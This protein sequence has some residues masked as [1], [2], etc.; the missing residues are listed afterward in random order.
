MKK[1]ILLCVLGFF[2]ISS[3]NAAPANSRTM[4]GMWFCNEGYQR[5]GDSCEPLSVPE[6]A[7][8]MGNMW[9]C[10]EGFERVGSSCQRLAV[11]DH[12]YVMGNMWF[13]NEGYQ[14]VGKSCQRLSV[15]ENAHVMG[16]MWLCNEEYKKV[17]SRCQK[18]TSQELVEREKIMELIAQRQAGLRANGASGQNCET[19][20]DTGAEV[21]I[22][23]NAASLDCDE[24]YDDS[25]YD[26]C[27]VDVDYS[28]ET[29]YRGGSYIG[30]D[31]YCEAGIAYQ[32]TSGRKRYESD[33]HYESHSLYSYGMDSGHVTVDFSFSSYEEVYKVSLDDVWCE[34]QSVQLR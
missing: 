5:V 12:A 6:N 32:S 22:S 19:E 30:V 7:H 31:V 13:C 18:M 14:R 26:S 3:A 29:D 2:L 27:E 25:Y 34:M 33:S 20:Y 11:P 24:S 17:G 4:G 10:N 9:F 28:L 23:V 15:P 16:N 1:N 21:C 8:V